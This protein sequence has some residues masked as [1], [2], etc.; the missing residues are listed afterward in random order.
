MEREQKAKVKME[1]DGS[2][3]NEQWQRMQ[4]MEELATEHRAILLFL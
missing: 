1:D 4:F 2:A 3:N